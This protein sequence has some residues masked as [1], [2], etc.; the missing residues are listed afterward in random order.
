MIEQDSVDSFPDKLERS[1]VC[2]RVWETHAREAM[3]K[4]VNSLKKK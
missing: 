2:R 4:Y 3:T 1:E